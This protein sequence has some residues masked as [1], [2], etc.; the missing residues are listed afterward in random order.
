MS[1]DYRA[2]RFLSVPGRSLAIMA[3]AVLTAAI[4]RAAPSP[5]PGAD[6]RAAVT[7]TQPKHKH[8]AENAALYRKW[9]LDPAHPLYPRT[10]DARRD[11]EAAR[12]RAKA[13]GKLL[14]VTF[15]ANWC[16]DCRALHRSLAHRD[17]RRYVQQNFELVNVDVGDFDRNTALAR[18]L[19]VDL[20]TGIPVAIFFAPDGS[21]IGNTN[22]GELE[23]ARSYTSRQILAF[24][25]EVAESHRIT[26]L[27]KS[28]AV[29]KG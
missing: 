25:R 3:A 20:D 5:P 22:H 15:G 28:S 9:G 23:P 16:P 11:Y 12:A 19:G 7:A 14:M 26:P 21:V 29:P 6:G 4:G 13:A 17:T 18:E 10:G 24:M 1:D 8:H 27:R 2:G